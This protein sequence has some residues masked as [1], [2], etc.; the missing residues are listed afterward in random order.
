MRARAWHHGRSIGR[1]S[2][3]ALMLAALLAAGGCRKDMR[4]QPRLNPLTE[5]DFFIDGSASRLLPA[6]TIARDHL[7]TEEPFFT[8]K[9]DGTFVQE[10]PVPVTADLLLRGRQRFEIYCTPCHDRAGTGNGIVVQRGFKQPRA[11]HD[12][13]LRSQPVG[14]YF[15][16]ITHGFGTMPDY[17]AQVSVADRWA[18]VAYIRTLQLSQHAGAEVLTAEDRARLD[19]GPALAEADAHGAANEQ[20][21]G[22]HE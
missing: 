17:A 5:S 14:Y 3:R 4:D 1:S 10:L 8:G 13:A 20:Q 21:H 6:N 18:I 19:A 22:Q 16:V 15:D 2:A 11:Y 12:P 9:A 7:R